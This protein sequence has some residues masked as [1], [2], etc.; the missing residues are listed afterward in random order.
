MFPRGDGG[1]SRAVIATIGTALYSGFLGYGQRRWF[2]PY[3]GARGGYSYLSGYSGLALS[4]ELGIEWF[5][6]EYLLVDSALRAVAF[7]QEPGNEAALQATLG[8]AVPF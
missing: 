7:V 2:N 1:D 5:K 8:V 4:A 6:H 3:V